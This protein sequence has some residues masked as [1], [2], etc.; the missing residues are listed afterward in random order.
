MVYDLMYGEPVPEEDRREDVLVPAGDGPRGRQAEDGLRAVPGHRR[1]DRG[2]VDAR[3]A[4][5]LPERTRHLAFG[6]VAAAWGMLD[7]LGVAGV[8]DEAAGPRPAGQPLST[9]TY[10]ALAAL[11]R[12]VAPCS[13]AA[14]ADWWKTTAADRFTKIAARRWTTAG[15]GTRCTP[16]PWSSWRRPPG[17]SRCGSCRSP[18]WT[19]VGGA[20][21]DEL[22]H[23][24]RHRERQGAD[25]A[26]RQGQAE[27]RRPAA[28]RAGPG[29]H[30]GRRDPADLACLPR[31]QARRHPVPGHDR[32]AQGPVRGGLRRGRGRRGGR[33]HDRGLR[34]R[35]E[36][37]GELRAPGRHAGC[38]TSGRCPPATART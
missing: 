24:H 32:P 20:G 35:A 28:G 15:S 5:V 14:F 22:R 11:N 36:L 29:G 3:E 2:A 13:K 34:R 17:R 4:A 33:G 6:D 37:R 9:G 30:P 10:L 8:I 16:S 27:T 31:R 7:E 38:T 26:A 19:V 1:G 23:L 18:G 12:L 21:H 25:R